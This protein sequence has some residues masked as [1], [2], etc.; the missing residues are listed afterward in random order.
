MDHLIAISQRGHKNGV[1]RSVVDEILGGTQLSDP[2]D[3]PISRLRLT[4]SPRTRGIDID[5]VTVLAQSE[6]ALPPVTVHRG[7]MTVIDGA[8][9]YQAAIRRGSAAIGCRFFDGDPRSA[10]VLS[11]VLNS[12][13]GL[14]LSLADRK[15]AARRILAEY[16]E[17]SDRR[18]AAAV[19]LSDKTV[20][21]IRRTEAGGADRGRS[22]AENPRWARRPV[23]SDGVVRP[24]DCSAG[25][26]LAAKL[27][28]ENTEVS[29]REVA[30]AA[31]ISLTTAK[32]VR[33]RLRDADDPVPARGRRQQQGGAPS[34]ANLARR[35]LRKAPGGG[36]RADIDRDT[37]ISRL[38]TDPS[39]RYTEAGRM[40][41][42][43]LEKCAMDDTTWEAIAAN[44]P[45]H[46]VPAI[47]A[48][49]EYCADDWHRFAVMLNRRAAAADTDGPGRLPE[50]MA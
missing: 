17:W 28:T 50:A 7:T 31:G 2:V 44:V 48:L 47:S 49:A 43:V 12:S 11:V 23:G 15:A 5:H 22:T 10:F 42:R 16:G 40:L 33:R 20:G 18:I 39:V 27:F 21:A 25:R 32:D 45:A 26:E 8:H 19:G 4:D 46:C 38:A 9:R 30:S 6:L 3:V 24:M 35:H 29:V 14:P 1:V 34:T 13:H 41:L 36:P 37:A